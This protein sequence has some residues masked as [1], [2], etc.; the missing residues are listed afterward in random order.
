MVA[1]GRGDDAADLADFE[2]HDG[3]LELGVV[4]E[5]RRGDEAHVAAARGSSRLLRVLFGELREI[6]ARAQSRVNCSN[7]ALGGGGVVGVVVFEVAHTRRADGR[8]FDLGQMVG[9]LRHI[10]PRLIALVEVGDFGVGDREARGD[11]FV[12]QFRHQQALAN[13]L[14][15]RVARQALVGELALELFFVVRAFQ[16]RQLLVYFGFRYRDAGAL[17]V[18]H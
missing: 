15:K 12:N 10:E 5:R 3:S 8:D 9:R 2:R 4:F 16:L 7:L 18:R 14:A 1:A 6:V 13:L 11:I 17:G